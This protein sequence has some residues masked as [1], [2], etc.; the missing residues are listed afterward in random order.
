MD[1]ELEEKKVLIFG[2][3]LFCKMLLSE[4]FL[5]VGEGSLW[6]DK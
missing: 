3:L 2:A 4:I 1:V 6:V 5:G